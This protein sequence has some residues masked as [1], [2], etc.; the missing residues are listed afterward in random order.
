MWPRHTEIF[1]SLE[2]ML[3]K[4]KPA[5]YSED[6]V[7]INKSSFK[8]FYSRCKSGDFTMVYGFPGKQMVLTCCSI[9]QITQVLNPAKISIRKTALD[10]MDKEMRA[11]DDI[12]IKYASKYASVANY[13]KK[14]IGENTGIQKTQG[15]KR[16]EEFETT[17]MDALIQMRLTLN[18]LVY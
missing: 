1:P 9:K 2:F 10:I 15:I 7:H 5:E 8:Y 18:I 13:Y 11:S 4:N 12:R 16:K 3:I 14:W 6:N 17:F